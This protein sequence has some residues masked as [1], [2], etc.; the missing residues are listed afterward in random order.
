MLIDYRPVLT[1]VL[2]A[3]YL[4]PELFLDRACLSADHENYLV[5]SDVI[6]K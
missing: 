6:R 5:L 1:A 4:K 2:L 3:I